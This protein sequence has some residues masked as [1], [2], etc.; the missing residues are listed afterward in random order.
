LSTDPAESV[1]HAVATHSSL[2]A[3]ALLELLTDQSER[4]ACA[5]ASSPSLPIQQMERLLILAGL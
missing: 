5:A 2:P 1:R 4:V 3:G